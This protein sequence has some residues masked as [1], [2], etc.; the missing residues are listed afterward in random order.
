[1]FNGDKYRQQ[2][3]EK[4]RWKAKKAVAKADVAKYRAER[5][6][7]LDAQQSENGTTLSLRS[8]N[9]RIPE[10]GTLEYKIAITKT[11]LQKAKTQLNRAD[12]EIASLTKV[13]DGYRKKLK[14]HD[15]RKEDLRAQAKAALANKQETRFRT[16]ASSINAIDLSKQ[17]LKVKDSP[18]ISAK[19]TLRNN[20]QIK[21]ESIEQQVIYLTEQT[22]TLNEQYTLE[23]QT[24]LLILPST[25]SVATN[26]P[27]TKEITFS[28][29]DRAVLQAI[30][31]EDRYNIGT[32]VKNGSKSIAETDAVKDDFFKPYSSSEIDTQIY[33]L[34]RKVD[35][36]L[37]LRPRSKPSMNFMQLEVAIAD[38][39]EQN[40]EIDFGIKVNLAK[41]SA[42]VLYWKN[43]ELKEELYVKL[44]NIK[45]TAN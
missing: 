23:Q 25:E 12:I 31:D 45:T 26:T 33:E 29:K 18:K 40:P 24:K 4:A 22:Q 37:G 11:D 42:K 38:G 2:K 1:M 39:L 13:I 16:L 6:A 35:E 8:T 36:E 15:T 30:A 28:E 27:Q 14:A 17:K 21:Y 5:L 10:E 19:I 9:R 44:A 3:A 43:G 7:G 34:E 41:R 32:L 20:L